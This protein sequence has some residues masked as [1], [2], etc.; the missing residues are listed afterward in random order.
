[1]TENRGRNRRTWMRGM[2]AV[3]TGISAV[4]TMASTADAATNSAATA[5][6]SCPYKYFCAYPGGNFT[7][8]PIL[9][10]NCTEYDMPWSSL[11][12]WINNQTPGTRAQFRSSDHVTRWSDSG[13]YDS[14][15]SADWSWVWYVKPC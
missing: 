12:S 10:Y 5:T 3:A 15:A 6:A 13:A 8:T 2:V 7:G 11:G 1:M 9:M 14:D 4:L